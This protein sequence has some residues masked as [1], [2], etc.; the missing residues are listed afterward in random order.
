MARGTRRAAVDA[1]PVQEPWALPE[2]WRWERLG[3]LGDWYGGGTP[4]KANPDFWTNG[5]VSWV[6]AKDMKSFRIDDAEDHITEAAIAESSAKRIPSGSV[7]CVMRSGILRH[8]FPVAVTGCEVTINQDL[9]ALHPR[10][11]ISS[12]Y[13]AHFLKRTEHD[14]LHQ[15]SKDGT[16]VNSID[17]GR[18]MDRPVP[19]PT[20]DVQDA[21]VA[22]IDEL[23]AEIDDG[24]R[25]L[26][27]AADAS[28]LYRRALLNSAVRGELTAGWRA[29]REQG[30]TGWDYLKVIAA[31][32]ER[33]GAKGGKKTHPPYEPEQPPR[34]PI[35]STWS[36]T[37]ID[38]LTERVTKGSS[39]GW[40]GFEYQSSGVLFVRSQ[41]VG[42]GELLLDE[43]VFL[44]ARF[45]E[46]EAKAVLK[47]GDVLLNIVGA[48]IGRVVVADERLEGANSNQAVAGIRPVAPGLLSEFLCLW[49]LSHEAQMHIHGNVVDV[50]RANF[51][52]DQ[53]RKM[54]LPLPP[55]DEIGEILNRIGRAASE[56][57]FAGGLGRFAA[58][59]Q[60]L[61]QSILAAAFRGDLVA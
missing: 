39:P 22:R 52:L 54:T 17:T 14:V 47:S 29:S 37:T 1:G 23:F 43:P 51:S 35:P 40:Q 4:S 10:P 26:R 6:S 15:C 24:E 20:L 3:D 19:I 27:K 2:G 55:E 13:V 50:A 38:Q 21:I 56:R 53:I 11:G 28:G 8:S 5:T 32:R 31:E 36:L 46:I 59:G 45:N 18:L 58:D 12:H 57:E 30:P 16:T 48:S 25:A 44:D 33:R 42:W 61:R 34:H 49:L 60:A 7:L 9:R 41:N